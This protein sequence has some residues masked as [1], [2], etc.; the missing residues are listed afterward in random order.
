MEALTNHIP[1]TEVNQCIGWD[2][3]MTAI[4]VVWNDE[5]I[6]FKVPKIKGYQ[7]I[8]QDLEKVPDDCVEILA[9]EYERIGEKKERERILS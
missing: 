5:E 3:A 2:A 7:V 1:Y 4:S 9:S 6:G 8:D